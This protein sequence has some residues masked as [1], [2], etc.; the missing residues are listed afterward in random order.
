MKVFVLAA[1]E[2]TALHDFVG[3]EEAQS[4]LVHVGVVEAA[5]LL[6]L[7]GCIE[8]LGGCSSDGQSQE[9]IAAQAAPTV[10]GGGNAGGAARTRT[11]GAA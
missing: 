8:V 5:R 11:R 6:D 2:A 1:A 3:V 9:G 7:G 4:M 10:S